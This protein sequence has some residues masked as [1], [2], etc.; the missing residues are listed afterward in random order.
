MGHFRPDLSPDLA[1][2]PCGSVWCPLH[3][4]AGGHPPLQSSQV[5]QLKPVMFLCL[6]ATW[7]PHQLASLCHPR[8]SSLGGTLGLT[9]PTAL[10]GDQ[11]HTGAPLTLGFCSGSPRLFPPVP[12]GHPPTAQ[13]GGAWLRSLLRE[14]PKDHEEQTF[15]QGVMGKADRWVAVSS[16]TLLWPSL[17]PR[18]WC[19]GPSC[20][21]MWDWLSPSP[22]ESMIQ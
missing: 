10:A 12:P 19:H 13:K 15:F 14:H 11:A 3:T 18:L 22:K 2:G 21:A 4:T 5:H 8:L 1:G 16:R 7:S 6:P 17:C 20:L 9:S